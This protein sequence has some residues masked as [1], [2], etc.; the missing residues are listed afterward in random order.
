MVAV[1][2]AAAR[3]AV[4]AGETK[5]AARMAAAVAVARAAATARA[6]ASLE[7]ALAAGLAAERWKAAGLVEV[8]EA[9]AKEVAAGDGVANGGG[10][11]CGGGH[12]GGEGGGVG[13]GGEGGGEGGGGKGGGDGGGG[14]G[15]GEGGGGDGGDGGGGEGGG[16][17]RTC[18]EE[19]GRRGEHLHAGATRRLGVGLVNSPECIDTHGMVQPFA[20]HRIF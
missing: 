1:R 10:G 17:T 6:A 5:V 2:A 4:K 13:G 14:E 20:D 18:G 12:G 9:D 8:A 19:K 16:T 11:I 15:G 7:S 3:T